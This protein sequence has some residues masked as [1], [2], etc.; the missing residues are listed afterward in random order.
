MNTTI[1]NR[2]ALSAMLVGSIGLTSCDKNDDPTPTPNEVPQ[3]FAFVHYVGNSA[4]VGTFGSFES[5]VTDNKK[6]FEYAFGCFLTPYKKN[7]LFLS[8][9]ILQNSQKI[10][11]F[12]RNENGNLSLAGS[13][14][15]GQGS[16]PSEIAFK[17][18]HTAYVSLRGRGQIGVIDPTEMKQTTEIDLSQYAIGDNNPDPGV[19]VIRENKL[20][21][22][23]NQ[24]TSGHGFNKDAVADVAII[25][26]G[27]NEVVKRIKDERTFAVGF[28][29]HSNTFVD[30]KGDV[31]FYSS[32]KTMKGAAEKEGFLRINKNDEWDKNYHFELSKTAIKGTDTKGTYILQFYYAGNGIVYSCL[33][34]P[35]T[36]E[37]GGS[38][39]MEDVL[40]KNFQP[41]KIDVWNQTI[42]KINLPLTDSNGAF[43]ITGYKGLIV[44]GMATQNATGYYTYNPA[45]GEC[46]QTPVVTAVG[47]PSSLVA[48]E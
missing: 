35:P 2:I 28:A 39:G 26:M 14:T 5:K 44:F 46:S 17:D 10:H 6:A 20:Y 29:R 13:I 1:F 36:G 7:M 48:F 47:V 23:L 37:T 15:F 32:G 25:D 21:V 42:E 8:E 12:T 19:T 18:A 30:E 11:K 43:A 45:T 24:A 3:H 41:V 40:A 38:F 16:T 31:Y 4:Y 27:K 34:I 33:R 22:A 9:G